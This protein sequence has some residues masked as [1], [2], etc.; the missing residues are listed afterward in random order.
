MDD[1]PSPHLFM[2]MDWPYNSRNLSAT[3][4]YTCPYR[5]MTDPE[6]LIGEEGGEKK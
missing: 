3:I 2:D 4:I 5:K 1:P 6:E